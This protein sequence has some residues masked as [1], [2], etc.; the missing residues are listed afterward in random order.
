MHTLYTR[1]AL[2]LALVLGFVGLVY[3]LFIFTTT[4]K[5]A[6]H[7]DQI[8]N[9]DLAKALVSERNLVRENELDKQALKETFQAYMDVNPSIEIYLIDLSGKI[10][11][12]SADPERVKR[13]HVDLKPIHAFLKENA[14]FPILGDDPRAHDRQKVFSVT[15][16][17]SASNADGYLY[18][19]LQG[20]QY[21]KVEQFAHDKEILYLSGW[22]IGIALIVSLLIGILVFYP[23]TR[24]LR[25]LST[26]IDTFR[27][28]DFKTSPGITI[29]S[30]SDDEL[31]QLANNI[32][33]MA[34]QIAKQ[35]EQ[36]SAKDTQRRDLFAS[37]SHDLRTPLATLNGY[38]ETL[39]IKAPD[40]NPEMREKYIDR[41]LQFC[42]QLKVRVDELFEL[43][44]LDSFQTTPHSEPFSLPELVQDILQQFEAIAQQ[45]DVKLQRQGDTEIPFI[46]GDIGLIQRV[47]ENLVSNAL[48]HVKKGDL[49]TISLR[50]LNDKIEVKVSDTGCGIDHH[51]MDKIFEPLY[52]VDN[53]HRGGTHSGLGLAIVRR[54][55]E[56]HGS[57]IQIASDLGQG[58]TFTFFMDTYKA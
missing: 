22:V 8:L 41:A 21:D 25:H 10:L 23:L 9:R 40:L 20:E 24:R 14:L 36:L 6:Q 56:L 34:E 55:L 44:K 58:T 47:L 57:N 1:L 38:L 54:I 31:N 42:N 32:H 46:K 11:S 30:T 7:A 48:R 52:Q 26:Q 50:T 35:F 39:Q 28:S 16:I 29:S 27:K 13:T 19:I 49:I 33:L 17:P 45:S 53:S 18:V 2:T 3:A 43:A 12:F 4:Q 51:E 37:L 15:H 5:S